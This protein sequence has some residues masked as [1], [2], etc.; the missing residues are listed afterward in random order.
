[1]GHETLKPEANLAAGPM[2]KTTEPK[3]DLQTVKFFEI[4]EDSNFT[5]DLHGNE[6][7]EEENKVTDYLS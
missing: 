2:E 6:E 5:K 4:Q 1:M 3:P 7:G